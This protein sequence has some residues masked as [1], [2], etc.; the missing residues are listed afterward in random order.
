MLKL[1]SKLLSGIRFVL[2]YRKYRAT[3]VIRIE[4]SWRKPCEWA[5]EY[6]WDWR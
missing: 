2:E 5:I 4:R 1:L 6:I 3:S